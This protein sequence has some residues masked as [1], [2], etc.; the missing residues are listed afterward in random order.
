MA[1][2]GY[3]LAPSLKHQRQLLVAPDHGQRPARSP[4][5]KAAAGGAL[6]E[7]LEATHGAGEALE[8][9][10]PKLAQLEQLAQEPARAV[11]DYHGTGRGCLLQPRRQIW[12]LAHHRLLASR[13]LTDK[14]SHDHE[15]GCDA[16]PRGERFSGRGGKPG[17]NPDDRQAYL[18]GALSVVLVRLGPAEVGEHAV[19]EELREVAAVARDLARDRVL[20]GPE[21]LLHLLRVQPAAQCRRADQVAEH[22]R[23]L[24]TLGLGCYLPPGLFSRHLGR[25]RRRPSQSRDRCQHD[26][27]RPEREP[28]FPQV[29]LRQL[30]Q[31]LGCDL[32]VQERLHVALQSQPAQPCRDVHP[33]PS[34]QACLP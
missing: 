25:A 14:G 8:P 22:N 18:H 30:S 9:G 31:N 3:R 27:P 29:D 1:L 16:D 20:V 12:R 28:E 23:E 4:G 10:R 17:N 13:A 15:A 21:D 32:G 2:A 33:S 19:S 5:L 6:A 34:D 7:D 24:S 11:G 26:L